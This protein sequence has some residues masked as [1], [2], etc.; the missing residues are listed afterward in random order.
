MKKVFEYTTVTNQ[1][2]RFVIAE[3]EDAVKDFYHADSVDYIK[4]RTDFTEQD[5]KGIFEL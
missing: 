2:P 3:N 4:E 1:K 5:R